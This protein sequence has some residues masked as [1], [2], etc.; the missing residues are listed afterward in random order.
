MS[1]REFCSYCK[2]TTRGENYLANHQEIR[3]GRPWMTFFARG[4]AG[5]IN[6]V[7]INNISETIKYLSLI[8]TMEYGE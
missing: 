7:Q 6:V 8:S 1:A 5:I 2:N 3:Y 4:I